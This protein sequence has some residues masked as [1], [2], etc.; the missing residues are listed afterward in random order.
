MI[1]HILKT[2]DIIYMLNKAHED[3]IHQ[4]DTKQHIFAA[5]TLGRIEEMGIALQKISQL[6]LEELRNNV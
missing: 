4:V 3:L 2:G 6:A 5:N 1:K